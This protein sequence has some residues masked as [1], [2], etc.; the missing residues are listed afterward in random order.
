MLLRQTVSTTTTSRRIW[1]PDAVATCIRCFSSQTLYCYN[2]LRQSYSKEI[3][4]LPE[5][6]AMTNM[7]SFLTD[8]SNVRCSFTTLDRWNHIVAPS[9]PP[10]GYKHIMTSDEIKITLDAA[11][12][13]F[14]LHVE[15][16][17][18]AL[19]GRGFYT[20]G[21][22]GEELLS[23]IGLSLEDQ[24]DTALHYRHLGVSLA[25]Q[26]KHRGSTEHVR[27][28]MLLDRA[29]G[30]TVSK[31]DPVTG[32]VHCSIGS[33]QGPKDY[34]VTSTLASQCP[35]A[36]GRA[37]G[38]SLAAKQNVLSQRKSSGKRSVSFVSVGDGSVHNH[39]FWSA[40]HLA[41]HAKHR[42]IQ[43]PVVFGIS[44]NGISISY[45]TNNYVNTLF[46]NDELVPL[47]QAEG[48]DMMSVYDQTQQAT[49]YARQRSA[50]AV[51]LYQ[52]IV[53]RF[54]HAASDRQG[55]YFSAEQIQAMADS[56]VVERAIV[57]AVEVFNAGTYSEIKDRFEE[58]R[59]ETRAGFE[60]ASEEDKVTRRDMM[61]RVAEP[62]VTYPRLPST[63]TERSLATTE[64]NNPKSSTATPKLEVMRKHMTRVLEESLTNDPSVV[65]LGED[66]EH[67][68]YYLVTDQLAERFPGRVV[69][70]PPD[71][72]SLLGA[73]MGFAQLGLT[74][75]VEI[76]YAKYLDCGLDMFNE[77]GITN[78]LSA[79]RQRNGMVVRLQGFDRGLFGG[80]FH[81]HNM[82][83]NIPPGID[84]VCYSNGEDY[85][86][87]FRHALRQAKAGRVVVSVDSTNLLN[88]RHVHDKDRGWERAYPTLTSKDDSDD[89]DA[90]TGN[91]MG[92]HDIVTYGTTGKVAMVTY[93]NG[94]VTALQARRSLVKRGL[95]LTEEEI[96][97][98]DCPCL[99]MV[100]DGLKEKLSRYEGV[101]FA[102][103][104]KEGPGS[105]VMSSTIISLQTDDLLPP[106][107]TSVFAP[108]T[109]NSL[110]SVETFLNVID[111]EDAW[112]KLRRIMS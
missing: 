108:R 95:L 66:V 52:N 55:A 45:E 60:Q 89:T 105:N 79:G 34:L 18:A 110:G 50:P 26:L 71:E 35:S 5:Q 78:W 4:T 88:L 39:N 91:L 47:F 96:D 72:T 73:A 106:Y 57:Q 24:D 31:L 98:L 67:G 17:I 109:Y 44:N 37:L 20:I 6:A 61:D 33:H 16:R 7:Q 25:R 3:E 69:D 76:P 49:K 32:G 58:L 30:Y 42:S 77:I 86:R 75:I 100:P 101:I 11:M 94:V 1:R 92:F 38:Y 83:S 8:K 48:S 43:C 102:D 27:S 28:Q 93:G 64:Q 107:W 80:N 10:E 99:S 29:R 22:C 12:A 81:T 104:C 85:V 90:G 21:P 68:G 23:A 9:P 41:R 53:R 82:L 36:V 13:A 59:S 40:F 103:I 63:I 54:G 19:C 87:G 2:D 84:V 15:S 70:F 51:V 65:Y 46:G 111:I 74:P 62:V 14:C 56:T 112:K 97:I